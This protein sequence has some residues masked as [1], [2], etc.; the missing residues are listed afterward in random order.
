MFLSREN[1]GSS[2]IKYNKSTCQTIWD[3]EKYRTNALSTS[4]EFNV[5]VRNFCKNN[6][7]ILK[8]FPQ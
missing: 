4:S 1:P 5:K 8:H 7:I 2:G 3:T 6:N